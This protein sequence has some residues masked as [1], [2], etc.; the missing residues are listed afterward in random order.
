MKRTIEVE[1]PYCGTKAKIEYGSLHNDYVLAICDVI[2]G[3]C[4]KPFVVDVTVSLKA[5]AMKVEGATACI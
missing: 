3:G 2:E 4:D 1:C 5:K